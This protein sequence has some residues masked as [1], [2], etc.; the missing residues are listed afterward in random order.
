MVETIYITWNQR[1]KKIRREKPEKIS[2]KNDKKVGANKKRVKRPPFLKKLEM[3]G[4]CNLIDLNYYQKKA[5]L[6]LEKRILYKC[7]TIAVDTSD[8]CY[9][10]WHKVILQL[11]NNN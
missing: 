2:S 9:Y 6:E 10:D 4:S 3:A 1:K 8:M 7:P 11:I 5:H